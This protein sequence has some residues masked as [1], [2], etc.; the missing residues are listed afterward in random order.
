MLE[1]I[2]KALK[3]RLVKDEPGIGA[4]VVSKRVTG[5]SNRSE[6]A[7]LLGNVSN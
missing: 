4:R 1:N 7:G 2:A 5:S 3:R 6:A